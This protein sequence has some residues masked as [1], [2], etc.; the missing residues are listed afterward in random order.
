MQG[1]RSSAES[2]A[3]DYVSGKDTDFQIFDL[4]FLPL[5]DLGVCCATCA[6]EIRCKGHTSRSVNS[7]DSPVLMMKAPQYERKEPKE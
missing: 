2:D 1:E 5:I 3:C 7:H 4:Y 6:S